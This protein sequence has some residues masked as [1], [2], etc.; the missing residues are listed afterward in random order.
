MFA[1]MVANSGYVDVDVDVEQFSYVGLLVGLHD[2]VLLNDKDSVQFHCA[3]NNAIFL[4]S[5]LII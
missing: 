3:L 1:I 5:V 4:L 2:M